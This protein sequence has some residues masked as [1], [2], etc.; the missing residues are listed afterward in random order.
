M[1][2]PR[3][4]YRLKY[5]IDLLSHKGGWWIAARVEQNFEVV[6][7]KEGKAGDTLI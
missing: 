7:L 4:Q 3:L 6:D 1:Q 5:G 2:R